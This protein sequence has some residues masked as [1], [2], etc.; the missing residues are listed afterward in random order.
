MQRFRPSIHVFLLLLCT[1]LVGPAG[2]A[3]SALTPHDVARLRNVASAEISPDGRHIAYVLSVPRIPFEEPDGPAWAELHVA[4]TAGHSRPFVTGPVNV[5]SIAWTRDGKGISFLARRSGDRARALY[6]IPLDGGEARKILEHE[7]NITAY[8]WSPDGRRVAF[9]AADAIP[10]AKRKLREQGFNQEIYEEDV[11]YVRVWIAEPGSAAKPRQLNLPGSAHDVA[12]SP[13][14]DQLAVVLAPTPLVDDSLIRKR[15]HIV[16]LAGHEVAAVRK[17]ENPGKLGKVVWSPDGR[18]LAMISAAEIHDPAEGRLMVVDAATG[19]FRDLLPGYLGH[20]A[21]VAWQDNDTLM[22]LG[23]EGVWTTFNEIRADGSGRKTILPAGGVILT[24]FSLSRDGTAAALLGQSPEHP[25]ELFT[26]KHGDAAPRRLT[27]SNP[28][29]AERRLAR[30]EVVRYRA[31]DGLELEGLLIRP[32]DEQPGTRYPLILVV[33]GGPE[34]HFRNG[35]LTSYSN[36]GQ[37]AAGRGFAVFYPNYR[38]STGRGVAFSQL[39]QGDPAGKEFD[40]LVDAV[41]HLIATGL[42]DRNKVGITGGSY[43]GYAS[44]WGATYYSERFAASVM[45]VGISD[46]ISKLGTTDIPWEM[47]YVHFR[48][49]PWEKWQHMLERSPI[50]HT[51]KS[52]T[53]TLILG[54]TDDPR[55]HPSQ[56][57]EMYRY[58]K[59]RS[60]APVRLVRYPGEEHGNRRAASRLDYSLRMLQWMEHYLKG[61]GGSPPPIELDYREPR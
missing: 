15:L 24:G 41:D 56:S 42:V 19:Q 39:S 29:L 37:M 18:R 45:F 13:T 32:L 43:G 23:D 25:A 28:W 26:M 1:L 30:Q 53:P 4:D 57:L 47:Y 54:G 2:L 38:G 55:V 31:R 8:S 59:L 9:L 60:Q 27:N 7:T 44:A 5:G 10:E 52:R 34:A 48:Y 35:W 17:V 22:F 36:P 6:V 61:P 33:H 51:G 50:Y 40:D 58:L 16:R 20:V 49:W 21:D 14:G 12:W 46:E 3:Q 11:P